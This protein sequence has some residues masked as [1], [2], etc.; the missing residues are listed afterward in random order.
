MVGNR[1][2]FGL[3]GARVTVFDFSE[4]QL[5]RDQE[6]A[7]QLGYRLATVQGDM[8]NI[9]CFPISNLTLSGTHFPSI[10]A[11]AYTV[12]AEASQVVRRETIVSPAVCQSFLVHGQTD[13]SGSAYPIRQPYVTGTQL[14][15]SDLT[16]EFTNNQGQEQR[17]EGPHEYLH[18]L[19]TILNSLVTAGC[20][21]IGFQRTTGRS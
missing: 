18:T 20:R 10:S 15:F 3:L 19:G 11:K 21:L 5:A 14:Q 16:W 7:A 8:R 6:T 1:Q 9:R 13:W 4:T 12:I 2:V 17:V